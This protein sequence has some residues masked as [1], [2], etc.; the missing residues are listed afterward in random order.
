MK[1]LL[2][3]L[4][5][6]AFVPFLAKGQDANE[7]YVK[8]TAYL[9][10][11]QDE[12][13]LEDS[14]IET[15]TYYD[16]IGRPIQTKNARSGGNRQNIEV[17]ME[18]DDLGLQPKQYLPWASSSQIS[19]DLDFTDPTALK[20]NIFSFYNAPKY[21]NTSNPYSET[22]FE[23]SPLLRPLQQGAPGDDWRLYVLSGD[24]HTVKYEY[25]TNGWIVKKFRVQFTG[26]D[27]DA[28]EL[29]YDGIYDNRELYITQTKDE[30]WV[31]ADGNYGTV[32]ELKNKSGQVVLK[33]MVAEKPG[34][35]PAKASLNHDTYYVYDDFGNLTYVLS[36]EGTD[37][38]LDTNDNVVQSNLD[39][40]GYQ[41]KYDKRNRLIEKKIPGKDWEYIVYD[42]LD[43]PAFTQDANLRATNHWLFT[44][45]D[46]L[47]R[48][49]YTGKNTYAST[50]SD[51][52]A[53]MDNENDIYEEVTATEQ[54]INNQAIYYTNNVIPNVNNYDIHTIHYYDTYR[55]LDGLGV[56]TSVLNQITTESSA[57]QTT[58]QGLPTVTKTRVLG[59]DDWISS[60]SA[61]DE[62]GRVIFTRSVNDFL[63]T[64]DL[65]SSVLDF[66]GKPLKTIHNHQKNGVPSVITHDYFLYDH[67]GRLVSHK[68]KI[69][70]NP[71]Q[72]I[73]ENHYD[74]LGQLTQKLVGGQ[75]FVDGFEDMEHVE[76]THDGSITNTYPNGYAEAWPSLA[77]TRGSIPSSEDGGIQFRPQQTDKHAV[78]GLV[79]SGNS[80]NSDNLYMDYGIH[81]HYSGLTGVK[82]KLRVDGAAYPN[83]SFSY[84]TY[85]ANDLFSVQRVGNTVKFL[86]NGSEFES[87]NITSNNDLLYGKVTFTGDEG[88]Q[89]TNVTLF[90]SAFDGGLQDVDYDYN[91]RGWLT[92]INEVDPGLAGGLIPDLF[93]FKINYNEV[94]STVGDSPV[95]LY[96]GNI[97][98]TLWQTE[99]ADD[100]IRGYNYVYDDL[101]RIATAKSIKGTTLSAMVL[102]NNHDLGNLSYDLN[103]NIK[104]LNRRGFDDNGTF[105][106]MWDDLTYYYN[107]N[108]LIR[109]VDQL[110]GTPLEDY[111]FKDVS[112][113]IDPDYSYDANGNMTLDKNKDITSI[114]YNH[115]NLPTEVTFSNDP[116]KRIEY[117]YDA[118]GIKL[119]KKIIEG[120][121]VETTVSYAGNLKYKKPY[122]GAG[123]ETLEFMNQP[124]GYLVPGPITTGGP[125]GGSYY[126]GYKYVFQ[127]KDHLGNIRLSYSDDNGDG[128]IDET[129]EIIEESNYYPFG[130]KQKGYNTTFNPIGN[131]LAQNWK[132]GGKENNEE[133]GLEW[134]DFSARNYDAA[135]GRF[136]SIDP[137]ADFA[138]ELTPYRY[139]ANNPIVF[140]DPTGL[141]EFSY[142][143][144]NKTLS[145]VK[146]K[147]KDGWKTFKRESGLSKSQLKEMFGENYKEVLDGVKNDGEDGIGVK[148]IGG[149]VGETLQSF[150]TALGEYNDGLKTA[151]ADPEA[152]GKN[153]CWGTCESVSKTGKVDPNGIQGSPEEFDKF[154]EN[155][156]TNVSS[157]GMLDVIRYKFNINGAPDNKSSHGSIFLFKNEKGTQLFTKNGSNNSRL[158]QV[159]YEVEMLK[160]NPNYGERS[161]ISRLQT[162]TNP[163]TGAVTR[164]RVTDQSAFYRSRN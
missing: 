148:D 1:K 159:M 149:E 66:S 22:S 129:T 56:P 127:Y 110:N 4:V 78:V 108:Q 10:E 74:E 153:N 48:V 71:V 89:L 157:G 91:I 142:D 12:S 47:G 151:S 103:G 90:S 100:D 135:L 97:A 143:E 51:L 123:I 87:V 42:Q 77:M 145:I 27:Y 163:E 73:A 122:S 55:H 63:E 20:N 107:G 33:R 13:V 109:V 60:F 52:Q 81:L 164:E 31:P 83:G 9:V 79:K 7:N 101:N 104:T 114:E 36:P 84:G 54:T 162:V 34:G 137:L 6:T 44:K 67:M 120:V 53:L 26:S 61:Y 57:S 30:N 126:D 50:R 19:N 118:T 29:I 64:N 35:L 134:Y 40:W 15:V 70:N 155:N 128:S 98:Q 146:T 136:M 92:E 88:A 21:D 32:F 28:P 68:Q 86:K 94:N 75:S 105:T 85:N 138:P 58:T 161:G 82:I 95:A 11:T 99:S 141:W 62:K 93:N 43:R 24:N 14:K 76:V 124:E 160:Q 8:S 23:S 156:T 18:Y 139:A 49:A 152:E 46:A 147:D 132:F 102:N 38:I 154:L 41:Y 116:Y 130:V 144:E 115:L 16:D 131:D 133:L 5:I 125:K 119:Q 112:N 69:G 106:D 111:G 65:I 158:Y 140:N 3:I 96:N 113:G 80:N 25:D 39:K 121:G 59:T 150:E 117:T 2:Y 72:R 45:Y 17:H 37:S